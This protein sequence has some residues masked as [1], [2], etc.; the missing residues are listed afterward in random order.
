MDGWTSEP[1]S[2]GGGISGDVYAYH[3]QGVYE[4]G[5]DDDQPVV[6]AFVRSHL[7]D[8]IMF[9]SKNLNYLGPRPKE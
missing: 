5:D 3:S 9:F 8:A 7:T 4:S 2:R 6:R 1:S